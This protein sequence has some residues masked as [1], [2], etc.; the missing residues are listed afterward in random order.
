MGESKVRR[1]SR[2]DANQQAIVA[3]LR[4]AGASVW[5]IGLPVDLL[6]GKNGSTLLLEVK[7]LTGKRKPKAAPYTQLQRDFMASW[8]GGPVATV[9][10]VESALRAIETLKG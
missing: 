9:T 8:R 4:A 7:T 1:A 10:D 2:V 6:C 5:Y 3:A